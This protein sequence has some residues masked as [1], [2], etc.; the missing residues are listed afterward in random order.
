MWKWAGLQ[1]YLTPVSRASPCELI[2]KTNSNCSVITRFPPLP[3][4]QE[5]VISGWLWQDCLE[6]GRPQ[7]RC[8]DRTR[9]HSRRLVGR[10]EE[11]GEG[12][13]GKEQ[14]KHREMERSDRGE[15]GRRR[16]NRHTGKGK[17]K[18]RRDGRNRERGLQVRRGRVNEGK[19]GKEYTEKEGR[20][21]E[22][23]QTFLQCCVLC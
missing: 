3:P 4:P 7:R 21:R 2:R 6:G 17:G 12:K 15:G 1:D 14:T 22:P 11:E 5:T 9:E 8:S 18:G 20:R 19:G 23:W 16:Q 10:R 13:G